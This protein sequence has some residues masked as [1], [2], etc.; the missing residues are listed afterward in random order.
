MENVRERVDIKLVTSETLLKKYAAKPSFKRFKIF[1][2][3]LVGVEMK[4]VKIKLNRPA[5]LGTQILIISKNLMTWFHHEVMKQ[6]YGNN[7]Q[8]LF[9]DTDSLCYEISTDD[10][11]EDMKDFQD[12]FDTSNYEKTKPPFSDRF[13]KIPGKFKVNWEVIMKLIYIYFDLLIYIY[14]DLKF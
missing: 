1:N 9:T 10:V 5:Y 4:R 14:F 12:Y 13:K 11:Y 3:N 6:K 7:I 2:E 8:L